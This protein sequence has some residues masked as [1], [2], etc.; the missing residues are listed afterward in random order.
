[1]TQS[2][3]ARSVGCRQSA[4]SMF[5]GGR[6]DKLSMDSVR[7][8]AALLEIPMDGATNGEAPAVCG[9]KAYCPNPACLGN[10]PYVVNGAL[11]VWPA[12]AAAAE[13]AVYCRI[14]GEVLERACIEC[15]LTVAEGAF[16]AACGKPRITPAAPRDVSHSEWSAQRRAE[17]Q[18]W[19]ALTQV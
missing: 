3:L 17:I 6:V 16:C 18:Q 12:V 14:C 10:I 2:A 19:R 7:K 5:E 11:I 13:G 4:V 15:G 9:Q 8:I 1:M